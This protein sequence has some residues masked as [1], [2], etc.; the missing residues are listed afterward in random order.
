MQGVIIVFFCDVAGIVFIK[1]V[2]K[3]ADLFRV[4]AQG[5]FR[6]NRSEVVTFNAVGIVEVCNAVDR[7]WRDSKKLGSL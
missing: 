2:N 5:H 1:N 3:R 4:E 6:E 7:L